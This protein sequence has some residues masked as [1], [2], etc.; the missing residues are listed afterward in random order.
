MSA[1]PLRYTQN[2]LRDP[3]LI[4]RLLA[5]SD[6]TH[7]DTVYEIGPGTG[8][9][10]DQLVRRCRRVVAIEKD[11]DLAHKLQERYAGQG[12]VAIHAGDFLAHPLPR[13]SYKVFANIPFNCT[14]AI[15]TK[16]TRAAVPPQTAYLVMQREAAHKFCGLGREYLY[17]ILLKPWFEIDVVYQFQRSDFIPM[18]QVEA[19]LLRIRK[20]GPPLVTGRDR[21]AFRDFAVYS[22]T[23]H[24]PTL[25]QILKNILTHRQQQQARRLLKLDFD[26][27]PSMLSFPQWLQLIHYFMQVSDGQARQTICGSEQHW[28]QRQAHLH[29]I[30][31]TRFTARK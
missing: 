27:T 29:K 25:S 10:T 18:P 17:S 1:I 20:R 6:L 15:V 24:Q 7:V 19:V 5:A 3:K 28:Q 16:L 14:H 30:H 26:A 4:E 2:F 13:E 11:A 23:G 21:Q 31:R 9:I 22:F 8:I 12:Q